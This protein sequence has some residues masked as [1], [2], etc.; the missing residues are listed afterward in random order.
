M[1]LVEVKEE[2][3]KRRAAWCLQSREEACDPRQRLPYYPVHRMG[4]FELA[5]QPKLK[6]VQPNEVIYLKGFSLGMLMWLFPLLKLVAWSLERT[7][8][9]DRMLVWRAPLAWKIP[10]WRSAG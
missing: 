2:D 1:V 9:L 6:K 8:A 5:V 7:M 3:V 10:G 4:H